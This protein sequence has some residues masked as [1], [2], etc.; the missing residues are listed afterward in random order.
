MGSKRVILKRWD[1]IEYVLNWACEYYDMDRSELKVSYKKR[2]KTDRKKI[3]I[4]LLREVADC[5]FEDI[6]TAIG[7]EG[8]VAV[9]LNYQD[10]NENISTNTPYGRELKKTYNEIVKILLNDENTNEKISK[11]TA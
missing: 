6:T 10:I 2:S 5:S 8:V 3:I 4:K 11:K 7:L 1:R 9:W